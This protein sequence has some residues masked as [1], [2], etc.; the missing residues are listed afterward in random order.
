VG[1]R[2][3][4]DRPHARTLYEAACA[5]GS[6]NACR[7]RD[8]LDAQDRAALCEVPLGPGEGLDRKDIKAVID[9]HK[10]EVRYCYERVLTEDSAPELDVSLSWVINAGGGVSKADIVKNTLP[11]AFVGE[12]VR[13]QVLRWH[14]PCPHGAGTVNVTFPWLFRVER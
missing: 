14:F 7:S 13:Q 2:V 4:Q 8:H 6:A 10:D 1:A 9:L 12:C 5:M 11:E 3:E